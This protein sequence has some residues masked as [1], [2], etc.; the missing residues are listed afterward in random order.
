MTHQDFSTGGGI[1][2]VAPG[3][4]DGGSSLMAGLHV[5]LDSPIYVIGFW[6]VLGLGLTIF[7]SSPMAARLA[8]ATDPY[9]GLLFDPPADG[10][11][12]RTPLSAFSWLALLSGFGFLFSVFI[13]VEFSMIR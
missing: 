11:W 9:I 5:F 7:C 2:V 1:E 8:R 6:V 3:A 13:D 12:W 10:K 4:V